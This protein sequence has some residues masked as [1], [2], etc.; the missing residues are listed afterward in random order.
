MGLGCTSAQPPGGGGGG[1]LR[2]A[3]ASALRALARLETRGGRSCVCFAYG[4]E[5]GPA[6]SNPCAW[7]WALSGCRRAAAS[8]QDRAGTRALGKQRRALLIQKC[9]A[10][11][12]RRRSLQKALQSAKWQSCGQRSFC[13]LPCGAAAG[14]RPPA[15]PPPRPRPLRAAAPSVV[16]QRGAA[17]VALRAGRR[18]GGGAGHSCSLAF[19]HSWPNTFVCPEVGGPPVLSLKA[20]GHAPRMW[21]LPRTFAP[22][23]QGVKAAQGGASVLE[24]RCACCGGR[25]HSSQQTPA[26]SSDACRCPNCK[27]GCLQGV[28]GS[29]SGR[30]RGGELGDGEVGYG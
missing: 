6:E 8:K 2:V 18:G 3:E 16:G 25:S 12:R 5:E 19:L 24:S 10:P 13:P 22:Q 17:V 14:P 20:T 28:G 11:S 7:A 4:W 15:G 29:A 9:W 27:L 30:G 26:A 1:R 23:S 21:G